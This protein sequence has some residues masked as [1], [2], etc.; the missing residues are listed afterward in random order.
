LLL[1]RGALFELDDVLGYSPI[2]IPRYWSYIRATNRLPVFYNA[3][4][5]QVPSPENVRL[6]GI[7]YLIA[8]EAQPLPEPISG[9]RVASERGYVLYELDAA[10]PRVSVV[11]DWRVVDGVG[12]ALEAV[13]ER[14]F[15]PSL[16]AIV[17]TDPG[18][19]PLSQGSAVSASY[20]EARPED[21]RIDVRAETPSLVVVRNAWERGWKATIDGTPAPLLVADAFL[22]AVAVPAGEHEI[23][24][25]YHEPAIGRGVAAS[26]VVWC[27]FAIA[28]A[29]VV[30][31][32]RRAA[33]RRLRRV[34]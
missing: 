18:F 11:S 17:E 23:R 10:Q 22:Q 27:A 4:V 29:V 9:E 34:A 14:R 1:G 16:T 2:Q 12:Q 19:T 32:E 3:A 21:V 26:A 20:D 6:L 25:T 31:I 15:D 33:T 13:T 24:L 8:H 7:R 28:L 30:V 5:I